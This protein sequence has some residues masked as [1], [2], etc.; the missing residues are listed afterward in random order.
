M[1]MFDLATQ[2][3]LY[4]LT[5]EDVVGVVLSQLL[6]YLLMLLSEVA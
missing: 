4:Q 2:C 3:F 1:M 5:V 6:E